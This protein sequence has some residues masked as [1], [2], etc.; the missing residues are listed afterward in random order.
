MKKGLLPRSAADVYVLWLSLHV[1]PAQLLVDEQRALFSSHPSLDDLAVCSACLLYYDA[2]R[3]TLCANAACET[4]VFC[5]RASCL[6]VDDSASCAGCGKRFCS[7][8]LGACSS[9][10]GGGACT[11]SLCADCYDLCAVCD[12]VYCSS[13]LT[14]CIMCDVRTC[15]SCTRRCTQ[16]R[17]VLC[18]ADKDSSYECHG[19][20][21]CT[22]CLTRCDLC[23]QRACDDDISICGSCD[24]RVCSDHVASELCFACDKVRCVD[25]VVTCGECG[26][27]ECCPEC[28]NACD[29]CCSLPICNSCEKHK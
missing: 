8:C 15:E 4:D 14:M 23:T 28:T 3:G 27:D 21:Y 13:H 29:E 17:A 16:C 19:E 6:G 25:C 9:D 22:A 24:Q 1:T 26:S 18:A 10:E 7:E 11:Q 12:S 5:A 2:T 20:P